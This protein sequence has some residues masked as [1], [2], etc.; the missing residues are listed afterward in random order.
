MTQTHPR[1][2]KYPWEDWTDGA[3]WIIYKDEDYTISTYNMQISLHGRAKTEKLKVST[4][5]FTERE[6]DAHG[7]LSEREGLMFQFYTDE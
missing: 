5:S 4:R 2:R 3:Q 1:R 6:R 7:K